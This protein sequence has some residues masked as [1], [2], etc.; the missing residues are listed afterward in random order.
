M[1][2]VLQF[3][4][5]PRR[6]LS[7]KSSKGPGSRTWSV[8]KV[9]RVTVTAFA[10][11]HGAWEQAFGYRFQTADRTIVISGDTGPASGLADKCR[12]SRGRVQGSFRF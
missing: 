6:I 7:A 11:K 4:A 1:A 12:R 3:V 9:E 5:G 10:V 2:F 8:R